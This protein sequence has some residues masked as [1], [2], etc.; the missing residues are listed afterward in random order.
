MVESN[1]GIPRVV[2]LLRQVS[3][4][5]YQAA[6]GCVSER[7]R[8]LPPR[9]QRSLD[10]R[11]HLP[12]LRPKQYSAST[13]HEMVVAKQHC[14]AIHLVAESGVHSPGNIVSVTRQRS[15]KH[16]DARTGRHMPVQSSGQ[17]AFIAKLQHMVL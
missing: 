7:C 17:V 1:G 11:L 5:W 2:V 9:T 16:H 8:T 10:G 15:P 14:R 4:G 12:R 6:V 13:S 3:P